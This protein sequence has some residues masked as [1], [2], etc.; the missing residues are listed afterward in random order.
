MQ[1][2]KVLIT[3]GTG[4][5]GKYL[6]EEALSN[7]FEVYIAVRSE[8]NLEVLEK[9][10][11]KFIQINYT[12]YDSILRSFEAQ[13]KDEYFF[14]YIIHNAGVK[15]AVNLDDFYKY[16]AD[17]TLNF[18]SAVKSLKLLK[19]E[20]VFI[21]SL[22]ASGPGDPKNLENIIEE[23]Q[24]KPLS[25]YGRSKLLAE[26]HLKS[27][28]LSYL[29]LRPTSVYG[30][31]T[32]DFDSLVGLLKRRVAVYLSSPNQVLSFVHA[33]DLSKI[34]FSLIEEDINDQTFLVSDGQIY[35]AVEFYKSIIETINSK[36]FLTFRIPKFLM[37]SLAYG[38][39]K[40]GIK[41]PLNSTEKCKEVLSENWKCQS[42]K[43]YSTIQY[44]PVHQIS[45]IANTKH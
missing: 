29:I 39:Q 25:A 23:K 19:Y 17:L 9:Y 13:I 11:V 5:I 35:T 12:S 4:F 3:G 20:F 38:Y 34:C 21:S 2:K 27:S 42:S 36:I 41:G 24:S 15:D 6:I 7:N 40:L 28:G 43:L 10:P 22:A 32:K 30:P 37:M 14:D 16:N 44:E 31:G 33:Q 18:A 26:R 8:S 45:E 1:K